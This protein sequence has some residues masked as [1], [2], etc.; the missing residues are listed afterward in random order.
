ME[1]TQP[2]TI[3]S[4]F[5]ENMFALVSDTL[6]MNKDAVIPFFLATVISQCND[7]M[8]ATSLHILEKPAYR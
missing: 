7:Y 3:T 4:K 1:S 6:L 2:K 8:H 5:S